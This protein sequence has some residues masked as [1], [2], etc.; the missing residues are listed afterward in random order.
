MLTKQS[1]DTIFLIIVIICILLFPLIV[2]FIKILSPFFIMY[3]GNRLFD[4]L[5]IYDFGNSLFGAVGISDS[6]REVIISIVAGIVVLYLMLHRL[7]I[8][9]KNNEPV[10]RSRLE[11]NMIVIFMLISIAFL[12]F[13]ILNATIA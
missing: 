12:I 5:G 13:L 8:E 11:K 10:R 3:L 6:A 9:A 2:E 7:Y 4:S 1:K